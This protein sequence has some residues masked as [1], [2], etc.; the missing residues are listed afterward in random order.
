[1]PSRTLRR[2]ILSVATAAALG[3]AAVG[4]ATQ[5]LVRPGDDWS[6]LK[7]K[8]RPGDDIVLMPGKHRPAAFDDLA[9]E[10]DRPI[11][12]KSPDP[13][14]LSEI[15]ATDI[16][17]L[18][19]RPKH[20]RIEN[21]VVVGGRRACIAIEGDPDRR[22]IDVEL[23]N[24][25]AAK[26]GDLAERA[27]IRLAHLDQVIVRNNRVEG[28]HRTGLHITGCNTVFVEKSQFVGSPNTPDRYGIAIDGGSDAVR[29]Q[30][31]RFSPG[32]G[33]AVAIG[34]AGI[35]PRTAASSP[36]AKPTEETE[37][38]T[39]EALA[40]NVSVERCLAERPGALVAFGSCRDVIVRANTVIDPKTGY[41]LT[42]IPPDT[43]KTSGVVLIANLL[44]WAP[45]ALESLASVAGGA[46]PKGV[47][48]ESNLWHSLELPAARKRLG[49]FAGTVAGDQLMNIDPQFDGYF[50]VRN[51]AA[52]GFGFD[53]P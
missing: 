36:A 23:R 19:R 37:E 34:V 42:E 16:G 22:G 9:G 52:K 12:I 33:T 48:L 6:K 50:R 21:L 3:L 26:S 4:E 8:I 5:H 10:R 35:E 13:R 14:T 51:E 20:V 32:I 11:V 27:C 7:D 49:E 39:R 44:S 43:A 53:A 2:A 15:E 40:S 45:G 47:T 25:Y 30:A 18:L 28:W 46:A 1:M 29:I 24:V 38:P 31:C 17:L 41:E